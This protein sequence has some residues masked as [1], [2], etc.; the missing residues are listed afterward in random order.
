MNSTSTRTPWWRRWWMLA[1]Y[2]IIAFVIV[3]SAYNGIRSGGQGVGPPP[4]S[5]EQAVEQAENMRKGF[6]CLSDWD[7]NHDGLERLVRDRL[8]DPDSMETDTTRILPSGSWG[9]DDHAVSMDFRARNAF[10]GMIRNTGSGWVDHET[11]EATLLL[12]D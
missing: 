7:G 10:G 3:V 9:D 8:N 12:I 2:G 1:T 6:H 5:E 4:L 11:C